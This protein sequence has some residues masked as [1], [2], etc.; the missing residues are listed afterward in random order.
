MARST[1]SPGP[2]PFHC[3][4]LTRPPEEPSLQTAAGDPFQSTLQMQGGLL[5]LAC[6]QTRSTHVLFGSRA[7]GD[8]LQHA[9]EGPQRFDGLLSK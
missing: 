6:F 2:R 3:P 1:D 9:L 7:V 8:E 4:L 5:H